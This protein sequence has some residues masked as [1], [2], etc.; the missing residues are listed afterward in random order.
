MHVY[1]HTHILICFVRA[2]QKYMRGGA[3]R[4]RACFECYCFRLFCMLSHLIMII[5]IFS[6]PVKLLWL[7][8]AV[9]DCGILGYLFHS[10]S[11]R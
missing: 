9:G 4:V 10:S 1:P 5:I 3:A 2:F 6:W 7:W 11:E 8:I